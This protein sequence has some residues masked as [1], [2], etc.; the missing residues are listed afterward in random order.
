MQLP[1]TNISTNTD[2]T[3]K[4]DEQGIFTRINDIITK[5]VGMIGTSY[6]T[7]TLTQFA[8]VQDNYST[9]GGVGKNTLPDQLFYQQQLITQLNKNMAADQTKYYNQ[10]SA[11][12][13]AMSNMTAQMSMLSTY[14]TS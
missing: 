9:T 8:N 4:Y 3:K 5:N 10:F 13:V 6:N 12:E 11:L 2:L 7:A 1:F 14:S